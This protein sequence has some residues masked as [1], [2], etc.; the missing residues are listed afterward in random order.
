MAWADASFYKE[1]DAANR[2]SM[3]FLVQELC[4]IEISKILICQISKDL[5]V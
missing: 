1:D 5:Q 4:M 3:A 2:Y